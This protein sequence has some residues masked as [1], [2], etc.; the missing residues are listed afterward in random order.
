ML[1]R[2]QRTLSVA[3]LRPLARCLASPGSSSLSLSLYPMVGKSYFP[4]TDPS[5]FVINVK[6]P[7]GTRLEL[8]D[9]LVGQVEEIVREVVPQEGPEDHR[10]QYRHHAGLLVHSQSQLRPAHRF[11]AGGAQRRPPPQQL[12][13][14][15]PGAGAAAPGTAASQ[16]LFPDR[17]PGGCHSQPGHAR[18]AG[19]SGQRHGHAGGPRDR[20]RRSPGRCAPCPASATCWCRRTWTIR[21]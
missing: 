19:Y 10:L 2:Y 5:Q 20:H 13:L 21:R 7:S 8:T 17:R 11:R 14:H 9:K 6:A 4:R 12:C 1:D 18:A 15:E 3:L 16:R